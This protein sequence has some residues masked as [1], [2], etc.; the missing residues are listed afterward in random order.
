MDRVKF[1]QSIEIGSNDLSYDKYINTLFE[2]I[3]VLYNLVGK[4]EGIRVINIPNTLVSFKVICTTE[5]SE[6]ILKSIID[7]PYIVLY[8]QNMYVTAYSINDKEISISIT[9]N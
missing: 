6:Y 9:K 7:N 3:S 1:F 2:Q 4:Y 5:N 8:D